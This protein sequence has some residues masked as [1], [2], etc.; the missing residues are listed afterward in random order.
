[1]NIF[2]TG[3][4]GTGTEQANYHEQPGDGLGRSKCHPLSIAHSG[5][6]QIVGN[7]AK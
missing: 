3:A 6:W 7:G 5:L 1:M 2:I 4:T